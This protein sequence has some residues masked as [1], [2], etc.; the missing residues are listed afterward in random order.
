LIL[1]VIGAI[2]SLNQYV[3]QVRTIL[4]PALAGTCSDPTVNCNV[5]QIFRFGYITI[6]MMALTAFAMNAL[7]AVRL[8]HR[9]SA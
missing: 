7:I 5:S 9:G 1:C 6:P 3:G 4:L 2:F 8:M